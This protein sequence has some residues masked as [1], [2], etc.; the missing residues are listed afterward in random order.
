MA[1]PRLVIVV[2]VLDDNHPAELVLGHLVAGGDGSPVRVRKEGRPDGGSVLCNAKLSD[3]QSHYDGLTWKPVLLAGLHDAVD[4]V[5]V[6]S[7]GAGDGSLGSDPVAWLGRIYLNLVL[8]W[9]LVARPRGPGGTG[10]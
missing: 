6:E 10:G 7:G 2:V 4:V 5:V 9:R 8:S 3:R 1:C